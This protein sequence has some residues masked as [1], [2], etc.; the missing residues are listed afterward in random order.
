MH[1]KVL[2]LFS[3]ATLCCV[4]KRLRI[5]KRNKKK[6]LGKNNKR[7][8]LYLKLHHRDYGSFVRCPI[9]PENKND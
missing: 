5:A 1:H 9:P 6:K 7:F 3:Q 4:A 2:V 8:N